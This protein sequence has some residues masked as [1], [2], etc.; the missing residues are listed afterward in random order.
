MQISRD[1][2]P[3]PATRL[4]DLGRGLDPYTTS[5]PIAVVGPANRAI[6]NGGSLNVKSPTLKCAN[7]AKLG[8]LGGARR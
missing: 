2:E 8:A 5:S 3:H 4:M 1:G 7:P 6:N